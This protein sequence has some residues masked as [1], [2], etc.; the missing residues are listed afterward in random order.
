MNT[1]NE[2]RKLKD[3]GHYLEAIGIYEKLWHINNVD[4]WL[5]WEYAYCLKNEGKIEKAIYIC[6]QTYKLDKTFFYNNDMLAWCFYLKY[7][8]KKYYG[9]KICFKYIER[10]AEFL[11][12][13]I[14]QKEQSAF[15]YIVFYIVEYYKTFSSDYAYNKMLGWLMKIDFELLSDKPKIF[16]KDYQVI[17]YQSDLEQYFIDKSKALLNLKVYDECVKWCNIALGRI[18]KFHHDNDIWLS[19]RKLYSDGLSSDKPEVVQLLIETYGKKQHWSILEKA[20]IL[21]ERNKDI[22]KMLFYYYLALLSGGKLEMKINI[23]TKLAKMLDMNGDTDSSTINY[24]LCQQIRVDNE[25]QVSEFLKE[26]ALRKTSFN[27]PNR[28][29]LRYIKGIW[30]KSLKLLEQSQ[31]G[32]VLCLF[33][34]G[35]SGLIEYNDNKIFFKTNSILFQ[36]TVN[37]NDKVTFCVIDSYDVAKNIKTKEAICIEVVK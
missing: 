4:K 18:S 11:I 15:S 2:A 30:V 6:K 29:S 8:R 17:E 35:L 23:I 3:D 14:K 13:I 32:K 20:A 7:F 21:C 34:N 25:W 9:K 24:R 33:K 36:N 10:L 19:V 27:I 16:K 28:I 37:K 22:N 31:T 5:G 1:R 26:K 12:S